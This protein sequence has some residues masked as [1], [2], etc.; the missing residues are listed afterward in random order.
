L[1]AAAAGCS[2]PCGARRLHEA[3]GAGGRELGAQVRAG[4]QHRVRR[5]EARLAERGDPGAHCARAGLPAGDR[6]SVGVAQGPPR[7]RR[8]PAGRVLLLR[9]A[10]LL[11]P[12]C[13]EGQGEGQEGGSG[14]GVRRQACDSVPA[15]RRGERGPGP[16]PPQ[17]PCLGG[18]VARSQPRRLAASC[19]VGGR[20][21]RRGR[22]PARR[23][24][25][26]RPWD[27]WIQ[28]AEVAVPGARRVREVAR[29]GG[30]RASRVSG[31][32]HAAPPR[33]GR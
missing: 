1:R 5:Q 33:L 6:K 8:L 24:G 12:L 7:R 28:P 26:A 18:L 4:G 19:R 31:W 13:G 32:Q 10:V 14:P 29:R 20:V 3:P 22:L 21:R 15:P 27:R 2:P 17:L 9:P 11:R 16:P 25:G 23:R 30:A